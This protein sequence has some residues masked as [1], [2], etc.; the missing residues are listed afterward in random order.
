MQ[1]VPGL[2]GFVSAAGIPTPRRSAVDYFTPIHQ[3][4]T[5]SAVVRELLRRSEV[6]TDEVGQKWVL[7]TFD[8]GVCMKAVP[9]IWRWPDD[10]ANRHA[11]RPQNEGFWIQTDPV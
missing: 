1:P 11:H 6:A 5:D 3:P 7:N 8:L 4:I 10:F 2:E 9:I